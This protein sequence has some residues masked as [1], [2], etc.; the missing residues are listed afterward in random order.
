MRPNRN[1]ILALSAACGAL[2]LGACS[3]GGSLNLESH[4]GKKDK[5]QG[6]AN[7]RLTSGAKVPIVES[8]KT[9][10]T[11][12]HGWASVQSISAPQLDATD[13]TKILLN[14]TTK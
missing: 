12:V 4:G 13:G 14:R 11:G 5:Q 2:A 10:A 9:V 3:N 1:I 7:M 8:G 6:V